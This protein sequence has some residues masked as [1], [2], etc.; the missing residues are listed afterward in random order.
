MAMPQPQGI[1]QPRLARLPE[2]AGPAHCPLQRVADRPLEVRQA[3]LLVDAVQGSGVVAA[4]SVGDHDAGVVGRDALRY[5]LGARARPDVI[6]RHG[7]GR[8]GQQV[9]S[10]TPPRASRWHRCAPR[11]PPGS[12][13][14][15]ARPPCRPPRRHASGHLAHGDPD[16]RR[17]RMR[18]RHHARPHPVR[19]RP[20]WVRGHIGMLPSPFGATHRAA[21]HLNAVLGHLGTRAG[22]PC[23]ARGH[24]DPRRCQRATTCG[25]RAQGDLDVDGRRG[26]RL[27]RWGFTGAN[28][29]RAWCATRVPLENGAACRLPLRLTGSSSVRRA[30][31]VAVHS[32]IWRCRP[33]TTASRS[34]RLHKARS[35]GEVMAR[36]IASSDSG[37]KPTR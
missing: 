37:R 22:G 27:G 15:P 6:H 14:A 10:L 25:A 36:T 34:S 26:D 18:C 1:L 35:G 21:T 20:V 5:F 8:N 30:S 31:T 32:A 7:R 9:S 28:G 13:P 17:P 19:R 33:A 4:P 24:L 2:V 3:L 12:R 11:G 23:G 29:P 16:P